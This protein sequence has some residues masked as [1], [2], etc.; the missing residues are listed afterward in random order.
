MI[1]K[2]NFSS[3]YA[4]RTDFF[5]LIISLIPL[6]KNPL[7][8]STQYT[9]YFKRTVLL[10]LFEKA[11][12]ETIEK[13]KIE[14]VNVCEYENSWWYKLIHYFTVTE[15]QQYHMRLADYE[16]FGLSKFLENVVISDYP[17]V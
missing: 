5:S 8:Q 4:V 9:A 16:I 15:K 14:C 17:E 7:L 1:V 10:C 11:F 2:S 13:L 12:A 6:L 3:L